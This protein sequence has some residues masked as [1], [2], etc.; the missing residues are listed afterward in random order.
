MT[1]D[2]HRAAELAATHRARSFGYSK[3]HD[4]TLSE[5]HLRAATHYES[6]TSALR[7]VER[8]EATAHIRFTGDAR[9]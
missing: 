6:V 1:I 4:A 3:I 7:D 9:A 5:A 8:L 2:S